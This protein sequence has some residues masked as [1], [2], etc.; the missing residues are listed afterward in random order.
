MT[1]ART[2]ALPAS[3][4]TDADEIPW[5]DLIP[6]VPEPPEDAMQ[7]DDV[8]TLI[9]AILMARFADDPS[10]L[11]MGPSVNLVYDSA[12]PGSFIVP[13]CFVV[14][15]VDVPTIRHARRSYRIDEWGQTP[16]FVLEVGSPS[17]AAR[18]LGV[19]REIY[20][21]MGAQEY[22]RLDVTG[23]EFY[24][25]PLVGERLVDGEYERIELQGEAD[26]DTWSRSDALGV[27]F[28]HRLDDDGYS[29]FELRDS[30]TGEWL[31][32]LDREVAARQTAEAQARAAETRAQAAEA[33][34]RE[35]EAEL[36]R[37]RQGEG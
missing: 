1:T 11:I 16:A 13:D 4:A 10:A 33:R 35:L 26:G 34:N 37:L 31:N 18:D 14:F 6:E 5:Y 17:T 7:Q 28:Y 21:S 36:E 12:V 30:E 32:F 15:G 24:G 8:I 27:D 20:T 3:S 23:G 2:E 9:K 22:W 25:E 19:K 29:T